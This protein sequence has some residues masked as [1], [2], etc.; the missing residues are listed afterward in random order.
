MT[1]YI[2][3][4]ILQPPG[5]MDIDSKKK[6]NINQHKITLPVIIMAVFYQ[7]HRRVDMYPSALLVSVRF[8]DFLLSTEN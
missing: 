7:C 4:A 8:R 6:K 3:M 1:F 5:E 2:V